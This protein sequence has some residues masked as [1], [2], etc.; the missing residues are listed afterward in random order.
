[1]ER[2]DAP[3]VAY[4]NWVELQESIYKDSIRGKHCGECYNC[5][6]PEFQFFTDEY[7]GFCHDCS[8]FVHITDTPEFYECGAFEYRGGWT[9]SV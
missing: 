3:A 5:Q 7:V 1:M 9:I 4:D 8:E 6:V 2:Y